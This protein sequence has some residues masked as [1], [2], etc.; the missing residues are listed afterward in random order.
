[1]ISEGVLPIISFAAEPIAIGSLVRLLIATQEGSWITIPFPLT[2]T[3]VF[4]VHKSIPISQEKYPNSQSKGENATL[5]SFI[6]NPIDYTSFALFCTQ[7]GGVENG[8]K[9]GSLEGIFE[10]K[11]TIFILFKSFKYETEEDDMG[12][13]LFY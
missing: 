5:Y 10:Q 13:V 2:C 3:R 12:I 4:A 7:E 8:V 9:K 6:S 1:M 11:S